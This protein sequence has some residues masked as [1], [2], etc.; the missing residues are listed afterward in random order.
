M[1]R[2]TPFFLTAFVFAGSIAGAPNA[3][4]Q[5][6]DVSSLLA[7]LD[8]PAK[9]N[10]ALARLELAGHTYVPEL[11]AALAAPGKSDHFRGSVI[12]VL[13]RL[14]PRP[15]GV[16]ARLVGLAL[17]PEQPSAVRKGYA[18]SLA[19]CLP[20]H[21]AVPVF[22]ILLASP[23]PLVL[24]GALRGV[25]LLKETAQPLLP[26]IGSLVTNPAPDV[27][28]LA[29]RTVAHHASLDQAA[30]VLHAVPTSERGD[31]CM[32]LAFERLEER[33]HPK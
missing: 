2:V 8:E 30:A 16:E 6:Q 5:A 33:L 28:C 3:S 1:V 20:A 13:C 12:G 11:F 21:A 27:R 23:D 22:R 31:P 9:Y 17:D 26:D 4:P 7:A 19:F 18:S 25:N 10:E 32:A 14:A 29:A 15:P 24:E